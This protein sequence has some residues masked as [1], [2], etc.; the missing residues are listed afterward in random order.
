MADGHIRS[1]FR[2]SNIGVRHPFTRRARELGSTRGWKDG[3]PG[4][5]PFVGSRSALTSKGHRPRWGLDPL[6]RE[7]GGLRSPKHGRRRTRLTADDGRSRVL[8][9]PFGGSGGHVPGRPHPRGLGRRAKRRSIRATGRDVHEGEWGNLVRHG[10]STDGTKTVLLALRPRRAVSQI[11]RPC[12]CVR[13]NE[14]RGFWGG[15]FQGTPRCQG[16][17][18]SGEWTGREGGWRSAAGPRAGRTTFGA[19]EYVA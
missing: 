14:I 13:T 9:L 16:T 15:R 5:F 1:D 10:P 12:A 8:R 3:S 17:R 11:G 2:M 19:S 7:G 6:C 4:T 18:F